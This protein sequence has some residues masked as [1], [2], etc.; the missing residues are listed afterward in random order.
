MH[1]RAIVTSL[2]ACC[3]ALPLAGAE[4]VQFNRDIRPIIAEACFHCHG[5][6]PG[7]R[8]AGLRL[9]T[10]GGFFTA[11]E[12]DGKKDSPTIV[13]GRPDQ[14]PLFQ[15]ITTTDEDD[16]MPPKKE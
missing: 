6:D 3:A 11:R 10:E 16:V 5:P 8:K 14:S 13:K 15:R 4:N 7:A 2:F 12:K 9:D 1:T